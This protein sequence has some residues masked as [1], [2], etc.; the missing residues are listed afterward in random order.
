[1]TSRS[2]A[3]Y[4]GIPVRETRSEMLMPAVKLTTGIGTAV[5]ACSLAI[6]RRLAAIAASRHISMTQRQKRVNL[7]IDIFMCAVAPLIVMALSY[8]PQAQR[9]IVVEG[10][11]CSSGLF[12]ALPTVLLV[13]MWP[14]V[15][16]AISSVYGREWLPACGVFV[17]LT[18][19]QS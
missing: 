12:R 2:F 10:A 13:Y 7:G 8:I 3:T 9:F 4:V 18:R 14:V 1:M 19:L 11:G 16:G 17:M 15:F 5:A 6:N